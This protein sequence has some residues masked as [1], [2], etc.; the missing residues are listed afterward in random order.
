[1][2]ALRVT[3]FQSPLSLSIFGRVSPLRVPQGNR[4]GS[5]G[6]SP[7]NK[8]SLCQSFGKTLVARGGAAPGLPG[9][10]KLAEQCHLAGLVTWSSQR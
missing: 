3:T 9:T 4:R 10:R 7:V 2:S 1:M 8:H 5:A 6:D